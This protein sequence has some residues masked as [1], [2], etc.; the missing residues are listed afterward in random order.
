M[1]DSSRHPDPPIEPYL[2]GLLDDS[3]R[4]AFVHEIEENATLH[5]EIQL[6]REIDDSITRQFQCPPLDGMLIRI[7]NEIAKSSFDSSINNEDSTTY[8]QS[9]FQDVATMEIKPKHLAIAAL[10]LLVIGLGYYFLKDQFTSTPPRTNIP[11]YMNSYAIGPQQPIDEYFVAQV[12]GD[13]KPAWECPP[14]LF[15]ELV[16]ARFSEPIAMTEIPPTGVDP[17]GVSYCNTITPQ[18]M[19]MLFIVDEQRVIVFFD[20]TENVDATQ[21]NI[22]PGMNMFRHKLGNLSMIEFTP[23]DAPRCIDMFSVP[24]LPSC[25]H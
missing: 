23:L 16:M 11:Y 14:P 12:S 10:L 13:F 8:S 21:I 22:P 25:N 20:R 5:D 24:E 3:A 15:Q 19:C 18:T 4:D 9:R 1:T 2:D 17:L 7:E 6:Q